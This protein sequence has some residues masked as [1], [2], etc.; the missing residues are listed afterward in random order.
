M[1]LQKIGAEALHLPQAERAQLL[2]RLVLNLESPSDQELRSYWLLEA[3]RRAEELDNGSVQAVS[4]EDV[5]SKAEALNE[6]FFSAGSGSR[7]LGVTVCGYEA[8]TADRLYGLRYGQ[9]VKN[10]KE[11]RSE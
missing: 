3:R 4:G 7:I 1:N 9:K 10:S 11:A 5:M 2:Q 6:L 8:H